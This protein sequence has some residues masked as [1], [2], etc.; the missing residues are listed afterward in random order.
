MMT[1]LSGSP[2]QRNWRFVVAHGQPS[3]GATDGPSHFDLDILQPTAEPA[4][5][6]VL[7]HLE[8]PYL[9]N[10]VPRL[11]TTE[12]TLT[13]E[14]APPQRSVKTAKAPV[15]TDTYRYRVGPNNQVEAIAAP[16]VAPAPQAPAPSTNSPQ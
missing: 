12:D 7:W 6:H 9:R 13:F 8:R 10:Q 11:S 2:G 14:L 15:E 4:S 5:P 16:N 3:C 1:P